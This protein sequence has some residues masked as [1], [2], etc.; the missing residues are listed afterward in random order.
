VKLS[1]MHPTTGGPPGGRTGSTFVALRVPNFRIYLTGQSVVCVGVWMQSIALDWLVL[2]LTGDPTAVGVTAALQFLPMLFLGMHGGMIADRYAT[3]AVLVTTQ[4]LYGALNAALATLT[5][6]GHVR[7]GHVYVFALAIGVV[8]VVDNPT[9]Q[10][11]VSELVP[12]PHLRN[13]I[14]LN[15]A[16]FHLSRLLGPAAA[17]VLIGTVGIGWAFA[18]NAT[19]HV[20]ALL[21]L[22]LVRSADLTPAP[23]SAHA[24]RQVRVALRYVLAH[25]HVAWAIVLVGVI[26][27]FGLKFPIVL[28][29]MAD[30]AF[31]GGADLYGLFNVLLAAGSVVGALVAG[32]RTE[33]RFRT[34]VAMAAAFGLVQIATAAI[35]VLGMFL[36]ALIALGV[37]NLAFQT[38]ANSSVQLWTERDMRGRVMGLYMLALVGGAPLGGPVIGWI[39]ATFGPRVGMGVCGTIPLVAAIALAALRLRVSPASDAR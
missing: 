7:V 3:R 12:A 19:F 29:A 15:S 20:A 37:V 16:V 10:V 14:A 28:T 36:V 5:I 24:P 27:T 22:A 30:S 39:T 32:R 6:L 9:R 13:A 2:E 35:P 1:R 8:L 33:T 4:V 17:A 11:F 23:A 34:L 31:D 25:P 38:M 26:G 21:A 18:A